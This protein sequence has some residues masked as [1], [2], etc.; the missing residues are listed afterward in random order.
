MPTSLIRVVL[1]DDHP[2][3]REGLRHALQ[4]ADDMTIVDTAA[5]F[6][7]VEAT[8]SIRSVDVLVLDLQGMGGSPLATVE[9]F[10]RHYPTTAIVVFSSS[11]DLA[12]ELL[13]AG[14][15]G[16]VAKEQLTRELIAAIRAAHRGS[17]YI[18]SDVDALL[19]AT[20]EF[21]RNHRLSPKEY[22]VLKLLSQGLTTTQ[23]AEA[24]EIDPRSVQNYISSMFNKTGFAERTQLVEWYLRTMHDSGK[25]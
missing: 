24:M 20:K 22:L 6:A 23:V 21:R 11:T 12:P 8:L 25:R 4:G 7:E 9:R 18:S 5:S 3:T 16:Y 14:V 17:V 2:V 19:K 10:R 15:A 13:K 1:A